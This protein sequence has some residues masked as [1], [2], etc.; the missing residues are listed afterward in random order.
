MNIA[1]LNSLRRG[2]DVDYRTN[3]EKLKVVGD[4]TTCNRCTWNRLQKTHPEY[5]LARS[6]ELGS[7]MHQEWWEWDALV[8]KPKEDGD[9]TYQDKQYEMVS[10]FKVLSY[11]CK[12]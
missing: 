4:L 5:V 2:I 3:E 11:G 10:A 12:C 6:N 1:E 9:I 7:V 8:L